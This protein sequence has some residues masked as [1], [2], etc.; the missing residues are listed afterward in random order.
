MTLTSTET[1]LK[2]L[3]S[4]RWS[5]CFR[6]STI[7]P[8][9]GRTRVLIGVLPGEGIGPEVIAVTL[10]VLQ[11]AAENHGF[12]LALEF[13]GEIGRPAEKSA[14]T[15]L[16]EDVSEFCAQLFARGGALLS[17]PGGGAPGASLRW[18]MCTGRSPSPPQAAR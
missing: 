6:D 17:G 16:S 3:R 8:G 5:E 4:T 1:P 2:P 12:D 13:G 9:P 18:K 14:G 7:T 11:A 10:E 15:A